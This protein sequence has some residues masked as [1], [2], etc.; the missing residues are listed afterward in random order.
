MRIDGNTVLWILWFGSLFVVFLY[1]VWDWVV[2]FFDLLREV[3]LDVCCCNLG[4]HSWSYY[5]RGHELCLVNRA[6]NYRL[7]RWRRCRACY[8]I[9]GELT[10]RFRDCS[11]KSGYEVIDEVEY[12]CRE[13]VR[14]SVVASE[15]ECIAKVEKCGVYGCRSIDDDKEVVE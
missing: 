1:C 14:K 4:W 8:C 12:K 6:S 3:F 2:G 5:G 11:F 13:E 15:Y 9:Q 10:G 7:G